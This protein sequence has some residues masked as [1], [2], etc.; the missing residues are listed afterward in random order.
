[1]ITLTS[2]GIT[3]KL[4]PTGARIASCVVDGV[5]T[6]F[7]SGAADVLAGGDIYAGVVCG[8][9]AGRITNAQFPL[10]GE[11][12]KLSANYGPHQLH[13]GVNGLHSRHWDYLQDGNRVTFYLQSN[14]GEEGF[15]G[16]MDVQAVYALE[17]NTLSLDITARTTRP[18]VANITNHAYWNMAGAGSV[19]NHELTIPG[20]VYFPLDKDLMPLG[21]IV[22]VAGT[23]WDFRTPRIIGQDYDGCIKLDGTRGDM[24]HGLRLRDPASGRQLDV[25]TT[26]GCMQFYTAIHWNPSLV[27]HMGPLAKSTAL[28]IEPQNIADA[29][30]HANFPSSILRP[31]EVYRNSMEWRFS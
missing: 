10:D 20:S 5:E 25:F 21:T 29:P 23:D 17:G 30:N 3:A 15:P 19:L 28:A 9:H 13:G 24:K 6:C 16:Q 8:R 14:D 18:T 22:P 26:E 12:V 7:G 31:G 1:M 4:H 2:P 11:I 27:G